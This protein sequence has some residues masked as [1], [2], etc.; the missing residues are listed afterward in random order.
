MIGRFSLTQLRTRVAPGVPID[1]LS[2]TAFLFRLSVHRI[3][4]RIHLISGFSLEATFHEKRIRE[5]P[6]CRLNTV[7]IV[8]EIVQAAATPRAATRYSVWQIAVSGLGPYVPNVELPSSLVPKLGS[9][10]GKFNEKSLAASLPS[11]CSLQLIRYW[12]TPHK[13]LSQTLRTVSG[14]RQW[15]WTA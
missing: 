13:C 1:R 4:Y 5:V 12:P 15:I 11:Y 14:R 7:E 6:Y 2:C 10:P 3:G 8:A 9:A